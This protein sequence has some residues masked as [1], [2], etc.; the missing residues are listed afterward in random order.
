MLMC[1]QV[2]SVMISL[3]WNGVRPVRTN[4]PYI[5]DLSC[6]IIWMVDAHSNMNTLMLSL[7][8]AYVRTGRISH[9]RFSGMG[10]SGMGCDLSVQIGTVN[11]GF[12]D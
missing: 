8:Y 10:C 4:V 3:Q 9:G 2:A 12:I 5:G 7:G 11:R 1:G 6:K